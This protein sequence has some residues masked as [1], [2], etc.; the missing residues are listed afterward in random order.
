MKKPILF[1]SGGFVI[2]IISIL[3]IYIDSGSYDDVIDVLRLEKFRRVGISVP[4]GYLFIFLGVV[5]IAKNLLLKL[6]S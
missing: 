2:V 5:G 1:L 6:K 3:A 4:F